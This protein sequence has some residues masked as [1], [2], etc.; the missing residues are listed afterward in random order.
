METH[1]NAIHSVSVDASGNRTK[2]SAS[3]SAQ[4]N[5]EQAQSMQNVPTPFWMNDDVVADV[6]RKWQDPLQSVMSDEE[7]PQN[8]EGLETL[9]VRRFIPGLVF[10]RIVT[11]IFLTCCN[12]NEE[13][14][15]QF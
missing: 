11:H 4:I 8:E 9:M 10:S 14:G 2:I 1:S 5:S 7:V 3:L 12:R 6:F 13:L 15:N